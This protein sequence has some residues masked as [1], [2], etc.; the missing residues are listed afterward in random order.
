MVPEEEEHRAEG[1][2]ETQPSL[3][4]CCCPT[5]RPQAPG[6]SAGCGGGCGQSLATWGAEDEQ[7]LGDGCRFYYEQLARSSSWGALMCVYLHCPS[8][9]CGCTLAYRPG[10]DFQSSFFPYWVVLVCQALGL[11]R[12]SVT[13]GR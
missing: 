2:A 9:I 4:C 13:T 1:G 8:N 6:S 10:V 3:G 11:D 12:A 7:C 5:P